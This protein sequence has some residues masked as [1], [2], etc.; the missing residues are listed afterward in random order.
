MMTV[1]TE[2]NSANPN[3]VQIDG[4]ELPQTFTRNLRCVLT[5]REK[6]VLAKRLV[7]QLRRRERL[8]ERKAAAAKRYKRRIDDLESIIKR[9]CVSLEHGYEYRDV[10]CVETRDEEHKRI[11]ITRTDTGDEVDSRAMTTEEPQGSLFDPHQLS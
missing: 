5:K 2:S 3:G 4:A 7:K 10:E 6:R 8:N 11:V 1:T 9:H